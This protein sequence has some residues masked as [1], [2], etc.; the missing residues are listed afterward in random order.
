MLRRRAGWTVHALVRSL[1]SNPHFQSSPNFL[2]EF[3]MSADRHENKKNIRYGHKA[4]ARTRMTSPS[5]FPSQHSAPTRRPT[6][7]PRPRCRVR[8]ALRLRPSAEAP[9]HGRP[10]TTL[11]RGSVPVGAIAVGDCGS[12]TEPS[13]RARAGRQRKV[14]SC[15]PLKYGV[16]EVGL[17]RVS[18]RR[19]TNHW[20]SFEHPSLTAPP[21]TI[22]SRPLLTIRSTSGRARTRSAGL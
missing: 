8:S 6:R 21:L 3:P 18:K 17:R 22:P 10:A 2:I 1:Q 5:N 4:V 9:H 20:H 16:R 13:I 14:R 15:A 11:Q 12:R 7:P 19:T